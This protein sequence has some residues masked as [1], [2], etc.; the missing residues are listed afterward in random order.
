MVNIKEISSPYGILFIGILEILK[1]KG[2]VT[3][4]E[5]E[6]LMDSMPSQSAIKSEEMIEYIKNAL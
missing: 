3:E 1:I 4:Q 5:I 6:K 2:I